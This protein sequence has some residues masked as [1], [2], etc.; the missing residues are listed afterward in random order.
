MMFE[1]N[2]CLINKNH[3]CSIVRNYKDY[4]L[5]KRTEYDSFYLIIKFIGDTQVEIPFDNAE[6]MEIEF[7]RLS[8]LL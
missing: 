3:I 7:K 4:N 1:V 5:S 6:K 8:D 2:G